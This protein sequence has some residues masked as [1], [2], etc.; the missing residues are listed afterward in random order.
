M[1]TARRL[2]LVALIIVA[3][4]MP[5]TAK[6]QESAIIQATATVISSLAIIGTNNLVFG[7]ITPGINKSVLRTSSGFAG[8][9]SL[10]G[11]ALAELS[12]TFTLPTDL[13][14]SSGIGTMPISFSSSDAAYSDG[15]GSQAVPTGVINPLGP[16]TANL[17][18]GELMNV[19]IGGT[20][21]PS[22]AQS[23]GDYTASITLSVAYTG[24]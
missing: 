17:G 19:W 22:I 12:L 23:G 8:E 21:Q 7:S 9:W 4:G 11:T 15:T 2:G 16:S 24:N 6:A 14:H 3:L 1:L 20:V 10:T 18:V 13:I 5:S